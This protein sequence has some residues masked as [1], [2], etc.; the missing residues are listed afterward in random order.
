MKYN[1]EHPDQQAISVYHL[2]KLYQEKGIKKKVVKKKLVEHLEENDLLTKDQHGFRKGKSTLSKLLEYQERI[3]D[4]AL[5]G[6]L[7]GFP[8]VL[9]V[10]SYFDARQLASFSVT[11]LYPIISSGKML[12]GPDPPK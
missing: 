12:F 4:K 7:K 11:I 3:M 10:P 6:K 8:N 1:Q 9:L 5:D 2:R